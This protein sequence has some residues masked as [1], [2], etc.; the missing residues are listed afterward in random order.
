MY[1][2]PYLPKN[3]HLNFFTKASYGNRFA[4]ISKIGLEFKFVFLIIFLNVA[5]NNVY[6][7]YF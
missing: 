3:C 4:T 6:K 5:E 7:L 1:M 2:K